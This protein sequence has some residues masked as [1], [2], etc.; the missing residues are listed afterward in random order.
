MVKINDQKE[1]QQ[2][3]QRDCWL[4]YLSH[5]KAVWLCRSQNKVS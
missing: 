4:M 5:E 1:N 2:T 3:P